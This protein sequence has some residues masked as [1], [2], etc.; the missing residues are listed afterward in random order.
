VPPNERKKD[1]V[2]KRLEIK[3]KIEGKP[4]KDDIEVDMAIIE[5]NLRQLIPLYED[6]FS[7]KTSKEPKELRAQTELLIQKWKAKIIARVLHRF[8]FQNIAQ[9]YSVFKEKWDKQLRIK[10]R[11]EREW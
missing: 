8:K 5:S 3:K 11:E 1:D 4:Q 7:R 2:R 6:F 10:E 9:R